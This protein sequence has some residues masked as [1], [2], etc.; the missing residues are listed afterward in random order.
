MR[1]LTPR[2]IV[3]ELD[4]HI[5][6][7]D[8]AKRAVAVAIRNRWRR[9]QL[10]GDM[11]QEV[12]PKNIMMIGPTGVG[13]TEIAR[14]LAKLTGA[15]FIKVEA[16]KYTEVGYYGR[17]VES[18][19]RELVENAIGLVREKERGNVEAE[20]RR[21][22]E[23]RLLDLLAPAPPAFDAM[24][25]SPN[26]PERYERTREKMRAMLASGEMNDRKVELQMEQRAVPMML[27]GIGM[28][29]MD[30]DLQGMFEKILPKNAVR[31]EMTVAQAR[32][33][34]FE[35]ECDALINAEK[36]NG[37]AIELAENVGIIFVDELDKVVASEQ[38][39][40]ADVSR[41]GVQ[42]DLLPIVEGTTV[43]TRYGYVRTD[44]ILFIAAGAFHRAKPSDLMPELQGR[45]PIRVELQGLTKEDFVRILTEPKGAL[46]KQY[47]ALLATEGMEICFED[48]AVEALAEFAFQVNQTTQNIGARRLYTIMERLLEELSFE[49]PDMKRG[50]VAIDAAYVQDRLAELTK[51]EDLSKFIL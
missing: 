12:A 46:T 36:V 19:I 24:P 17:D 18:M 20:A 37:T 49:A 21:R 4:R 47:E 38:T 22:V 7:Q 9:Q 1:D 11:R 31:R 6:G 30:I 42:R 2:Q 13:K 5:V 16:T 28:E 3:A 35:Q 40:G 44:H 39:H 45:F 10:E 43:Q 26:S 27:T 14:R 50:R 25:D 33:V 48:E 34:L 51:D 8:A 32:N 23:E 41:Q 15:P 29:Q